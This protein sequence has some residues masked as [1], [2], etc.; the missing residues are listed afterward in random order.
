[1]TEKILWI[2]V[3]LSLDVAYG[4]SRLFS[5]HEQD[6]LS[7]LSSASLFYV[8]ELFTCNQPERD[9]RILAFPFIFFFP[10]FIDQILSLLKTWNIPQ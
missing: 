3:S 9:L 2:S 1:M 8:L 5:V 10:A 4:I 6:L 7:I